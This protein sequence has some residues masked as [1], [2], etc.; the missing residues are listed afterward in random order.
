MCAERDP[1]LPAVPGSLADHMPRPGRWLMGS[2]EPKMAWW[3]CPTCEGQV[4]LRPEV[5]IDATGFVECL[6]HSEANNSQLELCE[7]NTPVQLLNY[8]EL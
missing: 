4:P 1:D 5:D 3:R 6:T 7:W 8:M 2:Q